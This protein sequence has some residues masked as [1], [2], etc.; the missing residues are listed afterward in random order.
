M[1]SGHFFM[2]GH[3]AL[4]RLCNRALSKGIL[5]P[6]TGDFAL[7]NSEIR[8]RAQSDI[9]VSMARMFE[10]TGSERERLDGQ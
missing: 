5:S 1:L 9:D 3:I 8:R 7:E 10:L 6:K 2:A 4:M